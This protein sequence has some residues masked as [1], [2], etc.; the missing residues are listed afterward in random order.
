MGPH[1]PTP[2]TPKLSKLRRHSRTHGL[3]VCPH[4]WLLALWSLA[5]IGV[6]AAMALAKQPDN[7]R[8]YNLSALGT[9]VRAAPVFN[10]TL[11][12][13]GIGFIILAIL[14]Y[15]LLQE[16]ARHGRL[17]TWR[18][19]SLAVPLGLVGLALVG[20]G[21]FAL[22]GH[23]GVTLHILASLSG[24]LGILFLM[25]TPLGAL[26]ALFAWASRGL[27]ALI[28]A[29]F[30]LSSEH[31]MGTTL[32]EVSVII[33]IGTWLLCLVLRLRAAAA[34]SPPAGLI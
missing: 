23:T 27:A 8:R 24:L 14:I 34:D 25:L 12:T 30:A 2:T 19:A 18:A 16:L 33:L 15:R 28:A 3:L 31:L 9:D 29:L 6:A 32:M 10:G 21:I 11:I 4:C 5:I 17:G 1:Q 26:G 22:N 7:F 20:A 13:T